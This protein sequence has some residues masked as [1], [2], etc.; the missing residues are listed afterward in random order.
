MKTSHH[1]GHIFWKFLMI[2]PATINSTIETASTVDAGE[3]FV[4]VTYQLEGN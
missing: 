1:Y 3:P 2:P 4:K